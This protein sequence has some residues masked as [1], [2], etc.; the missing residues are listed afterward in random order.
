M[1]GPTYETRNKRFAMDAEMKKI[2]Y[3]CWIEGGRDKFLRAFAEGIK[4][5]RIVEMSV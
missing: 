1:F 5:E 2:L 3:W 4:A